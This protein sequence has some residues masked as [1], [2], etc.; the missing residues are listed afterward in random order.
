MN[1]ETNSTA[2]TSGKNSL[3]DLSYQLFQI[4][5]NLTKQRM[6]IL[7]NLKFSVSKAQIK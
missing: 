1:P 3:T 7:L 2:D 6:S 4:R 5:T